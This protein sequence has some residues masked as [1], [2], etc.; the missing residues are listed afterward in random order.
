MHSFFCAH[1]K[2]VLFS[3]Y[4]LLKRRVG[5]VSGFFPLPP[6]PFPS[7]TLISL[8]LCFYT[9]STVKSIRLEIITPEN[10]KILD[11]LTYSNCTISE[12][13]YFFNPDAPK[14]LLFRDVRTNAV[15]NTRNAIANQLVGQHQ[16]AMRVVVSPPKQ[17]SLLS[18]PSLGY[19]SKHPYSNV[20]ADG[21]CRKR[22]SSFETINEHGI[23][24]QNKSKNEMEMEMEMHGRATYRSI[25]AKRPSIA[26]PNSADNQLL[27]DK[28]ILDASDAL[29]MMNRTSD[30]PF[31]G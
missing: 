3:F 11:Y 1:S 26:L 23:Q 31:S 13:F 9:N 12:I 6:S 27:G 14:R 8:S 16:T 21:F 30:A 24:Q 15:L 7:H 29:L 19:K 2:Q 22:P 4:F 25:D 17:Y 28:E 20:D 10:A 18:L 5:G